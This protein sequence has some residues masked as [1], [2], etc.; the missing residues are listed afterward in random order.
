[1]IRHLERAGVLKKPQIRA[2]I[3][4]ATESDIK[5]MLT[6]P[7]QILPDLGVLLPNDLVGMVAIDT[8]DLVDVTSVP[9]PGDAT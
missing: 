5:V 7:R 8:S 4:S 3:V 1:M 9:K 6:I 2:E